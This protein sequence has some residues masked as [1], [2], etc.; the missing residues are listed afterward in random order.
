MYNPD[1]FDDDADD[2]K[3][4]EWIIDVLPLEPRKLYRLDCQLRNM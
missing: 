4:I 1:D 3:P 2:V